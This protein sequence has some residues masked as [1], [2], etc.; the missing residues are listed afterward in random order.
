MNIRGRILATMLLCTCAM[1]NAAII[2]TN[3][4]AAPL[5]RQR[6]SSLPSDQTTVW[7]NYL[8]RSEQHL[9]ADQEFLRSELKAHGLKQTTPAP[10]ARSFANIPL[11]RPAEW[12]AGEQARKIADAIVSFQTPSGGWSKRLDM[13]TKTRAPG[14]HF[15][16]DNRSLYLSNEDF[17]TPRDDQ[18]SYVGTFDNDATTTQLRFLARVITALHKQ[19]ESKHYVASFRRGLGYIFNSQYPNGGWPQIWPVIG[20]YHDAVTYNDGA[21][22]HV[23]ELLR[24]VSLGRDEFAFVEPRERGQAADRLNLG[25]QCILASQVIVDGNRT[26]WCQQHDALTLKPTS[27]RNYEMPSLSGSESAG[28]ISFLM[29]LPEPSPQV[30]ESIKA[31]V[32]WF[33]KTE[34]KDVEFKTVGD[35]GRHLVP[36]PGSGPLW[37]RYYEIGSNRPIFGDRDKSIHD[38][39]EE[40]S[41]ERRI[42]YAWFNDAPQAALKKYAE[43]RKAR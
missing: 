29:S 17:D 31:A 5:T 9:R 30:V 42:G 8:A 36:A 19:D 21:M 20:G 40:I 41:R 16:S 38:T 13:T 23:L 1:C 32:A 18:W 7:S 27:A 33:E 3:V 14:Q 26:V 34:L 2:G 4:P 37:A 35:D 39:V 6:I 22:A 12:Y 11:G 15:S 28:L 10:A 43:W 24:D 25:I